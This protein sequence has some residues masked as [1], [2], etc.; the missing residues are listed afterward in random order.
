[1]SRYKIKK[2]EFTATELNS[3]IA[4]GMTSVNN[5]TKEEL[6][7][8][9]WLCEKSM[10]DD[11]KITYLQSQLAEKDKERHEEWKTGKEWKWEW[12]RV[13]LQLEQANQ[14]KISFAIAEL[15]KVKDYAQHIQGGLINFINNQIEE[16][17]KEMKQ[18]GLF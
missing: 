2:P 11:I 14:D 18:D 12:Q 8:I 6:D 9:Q 10:N 3:N 4:Y 1:M 17:K 7:S 16:L 5:I 13:N 15:E